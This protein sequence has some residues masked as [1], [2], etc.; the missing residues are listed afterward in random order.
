MT[1]SGKDTS[2][3]LVRISLGLLLFLAGFSKAFLYNEGF[4]GMVQGMEN[5]AFMTDFVANVL[6]WGELLLGTLLILGFC[7]RG[8]A[9]I[10]TLLFLA[11]TASTGIFGG[12]V[13][14]QGHTFALLISI[15]LIFAG[16]QECCTVHALIKKKD[17]KNVQKIKA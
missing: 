5:I 3:H 7:T 8:M 16:N 14:L 2:L 12:G 4:V 13:S 1:H 6:P 17:K 9:V 11:I 15:S 10:S